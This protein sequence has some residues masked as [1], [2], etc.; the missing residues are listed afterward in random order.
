MKDDRS[1][2]SVLLGILYLNPEKL[3]KNEQSKNFL[4][5]LYTWAQEAPSTLQNDIAK[6]A[7]IVKISNLDPNK[8]PQD[9]QALSFLKGLF[10]WALDNLDIVHVIYHQAEIEQNLQKLESATTEEISEK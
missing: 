8:L 2:Y 9:K 1:I 10:K 6:R 7:L 3:P 4:S 5:K